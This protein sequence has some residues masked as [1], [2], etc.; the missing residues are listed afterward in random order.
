MR[1]PS[2][3][4]FAFKLPENGGINDGNRGPIKSAKAMFTDRPESRQFLAK[5]GQ[6]GAAN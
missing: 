2:Q 4:R 5:A 3:F 6:T 1:T